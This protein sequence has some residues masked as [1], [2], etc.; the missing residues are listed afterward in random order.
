MATNLVHQLRDVIKDTGSSYLFTP[1]FFSF[2]LI[3]TRGFFFLIA[4]REE[5]RETSVQMRNID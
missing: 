5:G 4:V 2:F 1:L 3:L